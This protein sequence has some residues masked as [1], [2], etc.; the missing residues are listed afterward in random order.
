MPEQEARRR[1][2]SVMQSLGSWNDSPSS[3]D[4][5]LPFEMGRPQGEGEEDIE[6]AAVHSP[7]TGRCKKTFFCA[8]VPLFLIVA[9]TMTAISLRERPVHGHGSC[10]LFHLDTISSNLSGLERPSE[11]GRVIHLTEGGKY[12][13]TNDFK[14][15]Y[16]LEK[17]EGQQKWNITQ[18]WSAENCPDY[19]PDDSRE[20]G[21]GPHSEITATSLSQNGK[22]LLL[23][24]V[25]VFFTGG[26]GAF[27]R[28]V[29]VFDKQQRQIGQSFAFRDQ[30]FAFDDPKSDSGNKGNYSLSQLQSSYLSPDGL[31]LAFLGKGTFV[32]ESHQEDVELWQIRVYHWNVTS[33]LWE[34][35]GLPIPLYHLHLDCAFAPQSHRPRLA[36]SKNGQRIVVGGDTLDLAGRNCVVPRCYTQVM[37]I[38]VYDY[39]LIKNEW[40]KAKGLFGTT[41]EDWSSGLQE[42]PVAQAQNKNRQLV[43]YGMPG[44]HSRGCLYQENFEQI[45]PEHVNKNLLMSGSEGKVAIYNVPHT[46]EHRQSQRA[47]LVGNILYG[48]QTEQHFGYSL[49]LSGDGSRL[50]VGSPSG[51]LASGGFVHVYEYD[52]K[53]DKWV[54]LDEPIQGSIHGDP[55]GAS[56]TMDLTG[57]YISFGHLFGN[58]IHNYRLVCEDL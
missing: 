13:V 28:S 24:C 51:S 53:V 34:P 8:V 48:W 9:V 23:D 19:Y 12:Q 2:S 11:F 40:V 30:C 56:V 5:R 29:G 7:Q 35:L 6:H 27:Y 42:V 3:V 47:E 49:D 39:A 21:S 55:I 32:K 4:E 10:Q 38:Q 37:G 41:L 33:S 22:L 57:E 58:Q 20:N 50:V 54:L 46:Q 15:V 1:P 25:T 52:D 26:V 31:T 44:H 17:E 18:L 36:M 45:L 14:Y 43:A 16:W